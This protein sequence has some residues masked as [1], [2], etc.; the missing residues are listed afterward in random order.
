MKCCLLDSTQQ[1]RRPVDIQEGAGG[2]GGTWVWR[3]DYLGQMG[4]LAEVEGGWGKELRGDYDHSVQYVYKH[5][6]IKSKF[7]NFNSVVEI[8][9]QDEPLASSDF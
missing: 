1:L 2:K 6:I 3:E 9:L 7:K 4:G 5:G 8:Y